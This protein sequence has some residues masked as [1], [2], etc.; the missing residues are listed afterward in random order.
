MNVTLIIL[1]GLVSIVSGS[2]NVRFSL[3]SVSCSSANFKNNGISVTC[4]DDCGAGDTVSVVGEGS[5]ISSFEDEPVTLKVCALGF[6]PNE[7]TLVDGNI[8]DWI[9]NQDGNDCGTAG[10]YLVNRELEIPQEASQIFTYLLYVATV[11]VLLGDSEACSQ[12]AS[13]TAF[14]TYGVSSLFFVG[15]IGI[16]FRKRRTKS[17]I[18]LE[19][20]DEHFVQMTDQTSALA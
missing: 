8:C 4:S 14:L 12:D 13:A 9:S 2:K 5:A 16:F 1:L 7:L 3:G 15:G 19:G 18:V 20:G 6:C 11:K 17:M 10:N